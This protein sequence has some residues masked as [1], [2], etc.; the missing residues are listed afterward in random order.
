VGALRLPH[1]ATG[2]PV[3]VNV[4]TSPAATGAPLAPFVTVAVTVEVA[5]PLAGTVDGLA[6]TAM[7][8][9]T[10][11][12]T[13]PVFPDPF[14][15][16]SVAVTVQ[17]PAVVD[18]VY[19]VVATPLALV[20]AKVGLRVP[21][22]APLMVNCTGSPDTAAPPGAG[23]ALTVAVTVEVVLPSAGMLAGLA[24]TATTLAGTGGGLLSWSMDVDT[25]LPLPAS[26]AVT[27]QNPT[28]VDAV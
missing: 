15:I 6:V 5:V 3:S 26:V 20:V 8:F 17:V 21:H 19:V 7:L 12:C 4:T 23:P 25:L 24:E 16:A 9:G 2:L 28:V 1:A 18:A 27:V 10:A 13:T 14:E 22:D 11:V